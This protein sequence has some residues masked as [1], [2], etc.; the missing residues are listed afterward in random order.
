MAN[1]LNIVNQWR[2][3]LFATSRTISVEDY[4]FSFLSPLFLFPPE[5]ANAF[6]FEDKSLFFLLD[7]FSPLQYQNDD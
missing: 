6:G 5:D 3:M 4:P 1:I 2:Q 7:I